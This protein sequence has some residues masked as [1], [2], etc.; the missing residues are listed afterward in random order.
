MSKRETASVKRLESSVSGSRRQGVIMNTNMITQVAS[1]RDSQSRV[2]IQAPMAMQHF[3]SCF[4]AT[5]SL[6]FIHEETFQKAG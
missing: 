2:I 6:M 3:A 5:L 1:P 4:I